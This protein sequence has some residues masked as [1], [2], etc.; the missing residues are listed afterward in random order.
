MQ[1]RAG[2]IEG[3]VWAAEQRMLAAVLNQPGLLTC[4]GETSQYFMPEFVEEVN[5]IEP[6]DMAV[7]D[8]ES[9]KWSRP[10]GVY[11]P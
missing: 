8:R 7:F 11:R 3:N 4:W 9:R 5:S 10:G 6:V 2:T 1:Y